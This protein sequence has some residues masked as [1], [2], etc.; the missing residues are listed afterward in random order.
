MYFDWLTSISRLSEFVYDVDAFMVPRRPVV[1]T[2]R[3]SVDQSPPA[4]N[5]RGA[6]P[7]KEQ[8]QVADK[9]KLKKMDKG[10]GKMI[11]PKKPKKPALQTGGALK[12]YE[13]QAPVPLKLP[14]IQSLKKSPVMKKKTVEAPPTSSQIT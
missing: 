7:R 5:T 8:A 3:L 6:T 13:P 2:T 10:K 4:D 1:A 9:G 12:I 14:I 11:E